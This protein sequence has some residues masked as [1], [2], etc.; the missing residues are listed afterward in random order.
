M[1]KDEQLVRF[2]KTSMGQAIGEEVATEVVKSAIFMKKA[3]D[4][5]LFMEHDEG[6][7]FYILLEGVVKLARYSEDGRESILHIP[8]G[9]DVFAQA[10]PF[11]GKYPATAIA[12]SECQ[13]LFLEKAEV[14]RLMERHGRFAIPLFNTM[15]VWLQSLVMKIEQLTL[16]DASARLARFLLAQ[17]NTQDM[18]KNSSSLTLP[19]KKGDLATML[20]IK[21]ATLSRTLRRLQD[22]KILEIQGKAV[23]IRDIKGLERMLLPPLD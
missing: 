16:D 12:L 15:A 7:G 6:K 3:K 4:T 2:L 9:P 23:E 11:L 21:Q 13:L 10:S 5:I 8:E 1:N 17:I 20:N 14:L 22:E 18:L 19:M